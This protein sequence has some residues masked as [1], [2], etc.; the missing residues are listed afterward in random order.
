[1][2][3]YEIALIGAGLAMDALAVSICK[4]LAMKRMDWKTA[5]V[6]AAWFG[7]FQALMPMAGSLLGSAFSGLA[8]MLGPWVAFILLAL[9][10]ANMIRESF[11]DESEKVND[12]IAFKVMLPLAVATSIDALTVG[13]SFGLLG[14]N[15]F[16]A[17]LLIGAIT[18]V[19]CVFGVRLGNSLGE[20]LG[21]RAE[22]AGGLVLIIIGLKI[23]FEHL[24]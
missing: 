17:A 20:K 8:G 12:S 10:G 7:V 14:V 24:L 6:I 9:I 15:A 16:S 11:S 5:A 1:M 2:S 23:L 3:I 22:L 4:G 21:S 19:I 13:V 18:F